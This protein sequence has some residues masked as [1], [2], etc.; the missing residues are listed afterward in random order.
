M[1]IIEGLSVLT[2]ENRPKKTLQGPSDKLHT[3]TVLES[4]PLQLTNVS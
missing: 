1:I 3:C 4:L 2:T